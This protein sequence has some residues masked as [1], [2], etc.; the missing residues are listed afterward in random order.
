MKKL[1]N[2]KKNEKNA[3]FDFLKSNEIAE[4][5]QSFIEK[6][7]PED[8]LLQVMLAM[9]DLSFFLQKSLGVKISRE[10]IDTLEEN[11][12]SFLESGVEFLAID[13]KNQ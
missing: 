8:D 10:Y 11:I 9:H 4:K 1:K 12:E 6:N 3:K 5:I 7:F 2:M 13:N